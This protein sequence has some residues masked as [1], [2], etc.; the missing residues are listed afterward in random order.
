MDTLMV[1]RINLMNM[2]K[3][4]VKG[5]IESALSFGRTLDSDYAPLH[6]FFVVLEY[7]LKHGLKGKKSFLGQSKSF[8]G[9]LELVEKICPEAAEMTSSVRELPGLK[10]PAGK[11]RAWL[12]LA[13]MRK[14]LADFLK[15]LISHKELLSEF[16]EPHALLIE[17]EGAVVVGLLI[18]LNV[19]DANLCM[20]GEDLDAQ[21][22]L[23]KRQ[24]SEL[25]P[26][27]KLVWNPLLYIPTLLTTPTRTTSFWTLTFSRKK[28]GVIDYALYMKDDKS[29]L[30]SGS[31]T[32]ILDQKNYLEELN[33]SLSVT[34]SNLQSKVDALEKTNSKLGVELAATRVQVSSLEEENAKLCSD[35]ADIV[36]TTR[37][38]IEA[39]KLDVDTELQ[40]YKES[41]QGLDEL[42]SEAR[43]Q[44]REESQMRLDVEKEL[45]LQISMKQEMEMAMRLLEQD[46]HEKQD[47]LVSLRHQLQEVKEINLDLVHDLQ[48]LDAQLKQKNELVTALEEKNTKLDASLH[49][50]EQRLNDIEKERTSALNDGTK[51]RQECGEKIDCLQKRLDESDRQKV[52]LETDIRIER[53][54]RQALQQELQKDRQQINALQAELRA[55]D[56][57]R[58]ELAGMREEAQKLRSVNLEQELTNRELGGKLSESKLKMEDIKEVNKALQGQVWLKDREAT[59]CK[60][61]EKE[62]SIARRKHHCRNCGEIFCST[63]SDNELPLPSAP[64]PVRV[65][66]LCHELLLQRYSSGTN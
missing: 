27:S 33:K 17:E 4:S 61:C 25:C 52:Q 64:K 14:T 18:G 53:E 20:K 43:L 60:L 44:L 26:L 16:Y 11:G 58:Q 49:D 13:L 12:R 23:K 38:Q 42:Y 6:Q 7:C 65:C 15:E 1:E 62:F 32:A 50:Y 36:E 59:N 51:L 9:P 39:S 10:T 47:V 40:T 24:K 22:L 21:T 34:L 48:G 45:E 46:V 31:M 55:M 3:M 56:T 28:L 5:L 57:L 8:W 41:R 19:I 54:W 37:R 29:E 30:G 63:C 2:A 66:D 35:S